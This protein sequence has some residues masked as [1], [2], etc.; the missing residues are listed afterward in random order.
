MVR[1]TANFRSKTTDKKQG[2]IEVRVEIHKIDFEIQEQT[3]GGDHRRNWPQDKV[4][5]ARE[6]PAA[7]EHEPGR[8]LLANKGW[9]D[10]EVGRESGRSG[11]ARNNTLDEET[12]GYKGEIRILGQ[13]LEEEINQKAELAKKVAELCNALNK[14]H[15]PAPQEPMKEIMEKE[16]RP[17][18]LGIKNNNTPVTKYNEEES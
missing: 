3:Q 10:A 15:N 6:E 7:R 11:G 13:V 1:L 9:S 18:L 2:N 8:E 17:A 14:T 16:E 5:L 4:P 12:R